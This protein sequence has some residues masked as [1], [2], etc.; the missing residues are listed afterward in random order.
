MLESFLG[1]ALLSSP[2]QLS[3]S[4]PYLEAALSA[5]VV[6]QADTGGLRST[7][8]DLVAV[9]GVSFETAS[10]TP[11]FQQANA[12]EFLVVPDKLLL[13]NLDQ[14]MILLTLLK[15]FPFKIFREVI[16]QFLKLLSIFVLCMEY[17]NEQLSEPPTILIHQYFY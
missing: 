11:I 7:A 3:G 6:Q 16:L 14:F 12:D 5:P 4:G 2:V 17:S 1:V 10:V 15:E 9:V 8:W 13:K